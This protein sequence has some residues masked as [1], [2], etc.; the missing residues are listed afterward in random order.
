MGTLKVLRRTEVAL[1]GN[2]KE[3]RHIN[4]VLKKLYQ[5]CGEKG[6]LKKLEA[7]AKEL[8]EELK[9]ILAS[10][11]IYDTSEYNEVTS[12]DEEYLSKF[13]FNTRKGSLDMEKVLLNYTKEEYAI[14]K[15]IIEDDRV[16]KGG[17]SYL[18]FKFE[19]LKSKK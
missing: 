11:G 1:K 5:L 4:S 12:P 3:E 8:K 18:S 10:F 16:Y 9:K 15:K 14:F 13:Q 7:Q 19:A 6:K 2:K 17:A